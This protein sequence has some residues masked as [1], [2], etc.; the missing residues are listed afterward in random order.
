MYMIQK[1]R[2][3]WDA[4]R[5]RYV[6]AFYQRDVIWDINMEEI[7]KYCIVKIFCYIEES[8]VLKNMF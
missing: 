4:L 3:K 8:G 1:S 7:I 5:A 6:F 2:I